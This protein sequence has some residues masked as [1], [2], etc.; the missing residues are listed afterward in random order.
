[1]SFWHHRSFQTTALVALAL[2]L[3]LAAT[4][5]AMAQSTPVISL[6][7]P[8]YLP[9]NVTAD[10]MFIQVV[11]LSS[12][13]ATANETI[14]VTLTS[15]GT[16]ASVTKVLSETAGA[17]ANSFGEID[18]V[19][20]E[21]GDGSANNN[22]VGARFTSDTFAGSNGAAG[23]DAVLVVSVPADTIIVSFT[24]AA[25]NTGSKTV[26]IGT[27]TGDFSLSTASVLA[28]DAVNRDG[29]GTPNETNG[30]DNNILIALRDPDLNTDA[31]SR[32]TV[33][34][35]VRAPLSGQSATMVLRETGNNT[36]LFLGGGVVGNASAAAFATP[37]AGDATT[38]PPTSFLLG[39]TATGD[40]LVVR[41]TSGAPDVIES[42]TTQQTSREIAYSLGALGRI[43]LNATSFRLGERMVITITDPDL[44]VKPNDIDTIRRGNG[45][46]TTDPGEVNVV[47]L[48]GNG[49]TEEI[50]LTETGLNTGEFTASLPFNFSDT[51]STDNQLD[52]GFNVSYRV[53][54]RDANSGQAEAQTVTAAAQFT[55]FSGTVSLE[56]RIVRNGSVVTITVDDQDLNTDAT[57]IQTLQGAAAPDVTSSSNDSEPN[58]V[59]RET[60]VDTGRFTGAF[61]V[62]IGTEVPNNG[63]GTINV[64]AG[65]TITVTYTDSVTA[66]GQADQA[67]RATAE[68]GEVNGQVALDASRYTLTQRALITLTDPDL[69]TDTTTVQ[70]VVGDNLFAFSS[71]NP[72]S[73]DPSTNVDSGAAS[74]DNDPNLFLTETG[75]N[76]GVFTGSLTFTT[77]DFNRDGVASTPAV[78]EVTPGDT[79]TVRYQ[80]ANPAG[81]FS[82]AT[83][84]IA[85]HTGVV[86]LP[87]RLTSGPVAGQSR[88][89]VTLTDADLNTSAT[90]VQTAT[91]RVVSSSDPDTGISVT[92]VETGNDSGIFSGFFGTAGNRDDT[93]TSQGRIN[94][95]DSSDSQDLIA[96]AN[97]DGVQVVYQDARNAA[98]QA[99]TILAPAMVEFTTGTLQ[100]L[101]S[102]GSARSSFIVGESLTV[103]YGDREAN[104][105]SSR[106]DRVT[107]QIT[108]ASDVAGTPF[109]LVETGLDTGIFQGSIALTGGS[110]RQGLSI[111][112][113]AGGQ[114]QVAVTDTTPA[115]AQF[116]YTPQRLTA[117][118]SIVEATPVEI[119]P[120]RLVV[121]IGETRQLTITGGFSVTVTSSDPN[122]ATVNN[123]GAVTGVIAGAV[124]ITASDPVSG[125]SAT[126][127]VVVVEQGQPLPQE[128]VSFTAVIPAYL[129][130]GFFSVLSIVNNTSEEAKIRLTAIEDSGR[131]IV[132]AFNTIEPRSVVF[133]SVQGFF[134]GASSGFILVESD[135]RVQVT[136]ANMDER[137]R[138]L[139]VLHAVAPASTQVLPFSVANVAGTDFDTTLFLINTSE[140][141]ASVSVTAYEAGGAKGTTESLTLAPRSRMVLSVNEVFP[142]SLQLGLLTSYLEVSSSVDVGLAALISSDTLGMAAGELGQR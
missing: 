139:D 116:P 134:P 138:S 109:E 77:S 120:P 15:M 69:N 79:I 40:T 57:T 72:N 117:T 48:G 18:A 1:M 140:T 10:R 56:P 22:R 50:E 49:N 58:I 45:N 106:I 81:T 47:V 23:S 3:L 43:T 122:T 19:N 80:D 91:V 78:L 141:E 29:D 55:T 67:A 133:N 107:A 30:D 9:P 123:A 101:S 113:A 31:F 96:A 20:A 51:S 126:A 102:T 52:A 129:E 71:T 59:L 95:A 39:A 54:Y 118:A 74:S 92:L 60:G 7:R 37:A 16:G 103:R 32:Q 111:Q 135:T 63:D 13:T 36:G 26:R 6:D 75:P 14:T 125:T 136:M 119:T 127:Q 4:L 86:T 70:T 108:S 89:P 28:A 8:S 94:A 44:N 110:T 82:T 21:A 41:Y 64:P 93:G 121:E 68:V 132:S 105:D 66:T 27:T 88:I 115:G 99:E 12:N 83:A 33:S 61:R 130:G 35:E 85:S 11:D 142:A 38:S 5:P 25:G 100:L 17:L 87:S 62:A 98:G 65:G 24:N 128:A 42:G 112:V 124:V 114:I 46:T 73:T 131:E 76:T 97:G 84:T 2:G 104:E 53:E 34:V 90:S 137:F